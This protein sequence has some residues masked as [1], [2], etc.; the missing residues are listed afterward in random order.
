MVVDMT[1]MSCRSIKVCWSPSVQAV[2]GL[3]YSEADLR[4]LGLDEKFEERR[5]EIWEAYTTEHA[6]NT[7]DLK[8]KD[9]FCRPIALKFAFN[10]KYID[11]FGTLN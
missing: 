1:N 10:S 4:V 2:W 5:R 6:P 8:A 3:D 11:I 7:V 9:K